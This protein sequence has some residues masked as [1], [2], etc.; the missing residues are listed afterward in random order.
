VRDGIS[1]LG[2]AVQATDSRLADARA[3]KAHTHSEYALHEHELNSHT[4]NL[5]LKRSNKTAGPEGLSV[6]AD[7]N[8][9]LLVENAA[10]L[11]ASLSGG[12]AMAAEG[13]AAYVV[14]KSA[15]AIQASSRDHAAAT[16]I[17]A[18]TFALHLPRSL[19]G[20]K[21]SEKAIHAEG[22]AQFDGQVT[23]KGA[24]CI[25]VA[26]PKASNEAF[27]DGDLIAIENGV[28][29]KMR[30]DAQSFVGVVVKTAGLQLE[31]GTAAIRVAVAGLVS[32]RVYGVVKAGDKLTLNTAQAG[33]CK[34]GQGQDKIFAVALEAASSDRE[35]QVLSILVR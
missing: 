1:A 23:I 20:L 28:A 5:H 33:T 26:L 10:G 19:P 15:P 17:S 35:K 21:G 24:A 3:P 6:P 4:G 31:S 29:S 30:S 18:N 13:T 27:A 7:T 11:A 32:L 9:P 2:Q 14:S 16:L 12:V 34:V 22:Q 25:S 8:I